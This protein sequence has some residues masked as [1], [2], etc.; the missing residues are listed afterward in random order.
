MV[1]LT[2]SAIVRLFMSP[3]SSVSLQ[4]PATQSPVIQRA[5]ISMDNPNHTT[6]CLVVSPSWI[7]ISIARLG[8][9]L[10]EQCYS[11]H[12][13][14]Y[15][16]KSLRSF[17]PYWHC[18]SKEEITSSGRVLKDGEVKFPPN[19]QP[20]SYGMEDD[21]QDLPAHGCFRNTWQ[22]DFKGRGRL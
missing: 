21:A 22:Q 17:P 10:L 9:P 5:Q 18:H 6:K 3:C 11:G 15:C 14:L 1:P 19:L 13:Q 2:N 12:R 4:P 16:S 8:N 20:A 7:W